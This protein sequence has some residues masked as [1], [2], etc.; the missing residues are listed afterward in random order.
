[1]NFRFSG[2]GIS[3]IGLTR[4]GNE[5]SGLVSSFCIAVADGMGGHA[6]GEIA[7]KIAIQKLNSALT[8][9]ENQ[10]LDSESKS[11]FFLDLINHIDNEILNQS[12]LNPELSGM[13]TTFTAALLNRNNLELLHIGDSRCYLYR[14]NKLKQLSY[15]HTVMQELI[16]QGR[17]TKSEIADHPQRA[18]LTQA[19]MGNSGIEPVLI[20]Y[21]VKLDD[22]IL[23]CSDGLTNVITEAQISEI[24][25]ENDDEK[26]PSMLIEATKSKGAPDNVTV[27]WARITEEIKATKTQILGSAAI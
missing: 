4:D 11:D 6:G 27:I 22:A 5:D 16:D 19:L 24:V 7:S 15:D 9:L 3:D 2:Y 20:N 17:L 25:K 14:K 21:S 13:G 26:I 18:L 8:L 10:D 12:N 23:I 1:M